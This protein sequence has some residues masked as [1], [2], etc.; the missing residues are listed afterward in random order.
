MEKLTRIT[1]DAVPEPASGNFC[2]ALQVGGQLFISGMTADDPGT[3]AYGQSVSCLAKIQALVEAAGGT[4][5][6]IVKITVF[7]TSMDHREAFTRARAEFFPGRKPCSSLIGIAAL[8]DPDLVVEV[9]AV[10][11]IGAGS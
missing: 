8:A 2:N 9:E 4:L 7:L 3:D 6:D 5:D 1:T 10:A 11:F